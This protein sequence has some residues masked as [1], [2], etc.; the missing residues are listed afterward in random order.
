MIKTNPFLLTDFYKVSHI[1]QYPANTTLVYSNFTPRS[2]KYAYGIDQMTFF[3]LQYFIKEYL[4]SYFNDNF[5]NQPK[6]LVI[7][8]YKRRIKTSLGADLPN[9]KHLEDLHMLGYLPI[10]IKALPEGVAVNMKVPVLTIVNTLPEYFWLTNFIESLMSAT[11]WQPCTSAS[12]AKQYRTI[13]DKWADKTGMSTE[14]FTQ[15]QGHDFSFRGMSSLESAMLSGMGHLLS[16]TGSDTIPAIEGLETYYGAN[17]DQELIGGSVAASEHSVMCAGGKDGELETF[18]RLITEVYPSGIVSIVSDTWDLW[19]VIT[20]YLPVLK[21][22][23]MARNG[24][25]VIRPDSGNPADIL[26]GI[27]PYDDDFDWTTTDKFTRNGKV[28]KIDRMSLNDF[29]QEFGDGQEFELERFIME[30]SEDVDIVGKGLVELLWDTFG[31]T[32]NEKGYK[33]LDS[34]IGA[35]Y[36]DSITLA[37]AEEICSRLEQKGFALQVIFGIGSYTYQHNTRDTF[38]LA[39]K[40]T[41]VEINGKGV[42]IMKD[43]ITDNGVKKSATGLLQVKLVDGQYVLKDNCTEQEEGD[44][45][46]QTVFEDGNIIQELT[47]NQIRSNVKL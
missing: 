18:R 30:T 5:F 22:Q 20:E 3:G 23:I 1:N 8:Q 47:L 19:K 39:M 27:P 7:E 25:V 41:Y 42:N 37:R 29:I 4:I 46:L 44:S 10:K 15:W 33:V 11:L 32:I 12:I 2:S 36:G 9:Y 26:C 24:K 38:G 17:A 45:E 43:P 28:C 40:A 34:H 35:I 6:D 14:F 16:F 31:G 21:D 13:L